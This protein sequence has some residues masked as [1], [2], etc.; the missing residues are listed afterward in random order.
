MASSVVNYF[1]GF[2]AF[3]KTKNTDFIRDLILSTTLMLHGLNLIKGTAQQE[4]DN[5]L[6][7]THADATRRQR[8][9]QSAFTQS[10]KK[11]SHNVFIEINQKIV[12]HSYP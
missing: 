7:M 6:Q 10:R 9:T 4:L 12:E 2:N 3:C 1:F 11:F 5:T 8:V